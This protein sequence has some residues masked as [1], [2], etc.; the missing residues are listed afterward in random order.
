M[1]GVG[2][3]SLSASGAASTGGEL[4]KLVTV[5]FRLGVGFFAGAGGFAGG[6]VVS[7][8]TSGL[9]GGSVRLSAEFGAGP[10]FG[11]SLG[12]GSGSLGIG[13]AFGG[14]GAGLGGG[15]DFCF[16]EVECVDA[17]CLAQE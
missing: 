5:C 11:G 7:G 15:V 6:G 4:C 14:V 2:G 12:A 8:N 13:R 9:G 10:A 17:A 3:V 1:F 16:T